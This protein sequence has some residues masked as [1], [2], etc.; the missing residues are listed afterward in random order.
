MYPSPF[1]TPDVSLL[2]GCYVTARLSLPFDATA[3]E[4]YFVIGCKTCWNNKYFHLYRKSSYIYNK[5]FSWFSSSNGFIPTAESKT[6]EQQNLDSKFSRLHCL[7]PWFWKLIII[8]HLHYFHFSIKKGLLRKFCS[9]WENRSMFLWLLKWVL[10]WHRF[11]WTRHGTIPTP[12]GEYNYPNSFNICLRL[13]II[14]QLHPESIHANQNRTIRIPLKISP[15]HPPTL[16]K[17]HYV[18]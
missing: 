9:G 16:S 5:K 17:W 8:F 7:W 14:I 1:L 10:E 18:Y 11:L 2:T 3:S 12:G 6:A 4:L 15:Y 13:S